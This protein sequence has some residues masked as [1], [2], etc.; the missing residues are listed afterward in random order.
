MATRLAPGEKY[1]GRRPDRVVINTS[2][3]QEAYE[4]VRQ[5]VPP[6]RKDLG[7]WLSQVLIESRVREEAK[8]EERERVR[9]MLSESEK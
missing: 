8:K 7:R 1:A 3:T 5:H 2:I 4:Y 9:A 6:G